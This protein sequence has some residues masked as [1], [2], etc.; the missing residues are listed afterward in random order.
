[1]MEICDGVSTG[2]GIIISYYTLTMHASEGE[3]VCEII[4]WYIIMI[5]TDSGSSLS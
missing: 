3:M 1:M 2:N 5:A 4:L